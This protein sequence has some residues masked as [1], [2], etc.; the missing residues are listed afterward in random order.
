MSGIDKR[1][2]REDIMSIIYHIDEDEK[3]WDF[4]CHE[5]AII[6]PRELKKKGYENATTYHGYV[7]YNTYVLTKEIMRNIGANFSQILDGE[8]DLEELRNTWSSPFLHSW[9]ELENLII[10]FHPEIRCSRFHVQDVLIL[11]DKKGIK[12]RAKYYRTGK[13]FNLFNK[14]F[15]C[16]PILYSPFIYFSKLKFK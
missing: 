2:L 1:R 10:D 3:N 13:K 4:R 14:S 7:K 16:I 5:I 8:E 6:L 15:V 9:C 12:N 11:H